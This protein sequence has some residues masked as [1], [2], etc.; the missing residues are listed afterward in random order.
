MTQK[1]IDQ[2]RELHQKETDYGTSGSNY[3]EEVCLVIDYLKPETVLD[4]GCGKA[5]LI[6]QLQKKISGH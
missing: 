3:F 2:Y 5:V 6:T 1:L 4:Y